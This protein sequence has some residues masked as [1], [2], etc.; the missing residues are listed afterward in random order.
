MRLFFR[1]F[2]LLLAPAL[3]LAAGCGSGLVTA[4]SSNAAFSV[5]P[6]IGVD[7]HQLHRMQCD[8]RARRSVHQFTATLPNG[9]PAEVTWSVSGGDAT[10]GPGSISASGQYTPPS[11]LTADRA[12]VVVTAALAANPSLRAS[13]VLTVTPGFLQP[14]TPENVA[15]GANGSVT[16]TG[17]LAEAGGSTGIHSNWPTRRQVKAKLDTGLARHHQLPARQARPSPPAQSPTPRPLRCSHRRHLRG[18]HGRGRL[19]GAGSKASAVVLV[20]TAGVTAIRP[21]IRGSCQRRSRW[22]APA[23]TTPTTTR[24]ATRLWTAAA[25]RW[26]RSSKTRASANTC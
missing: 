26:A 5:T 25:A 1:N 4:N 22:A 14:L 10:S 24:A 19:S 20:N 6:G 12:E 18:G 9:S 2:S 3:L 16:I 7:R 8:Q 15:L 13:S 11:Y 21:H 17:I 23:A